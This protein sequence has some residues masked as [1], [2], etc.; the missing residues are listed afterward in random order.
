MNGMQLE[1]FQQDK[2][3]T[4]TEPPEEGGAKKQV[5]AIPVLLPAVCAML[6]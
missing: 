4:G 5:P 2:K 3:N 1:R 6:I